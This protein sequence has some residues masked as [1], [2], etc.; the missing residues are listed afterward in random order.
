M[1]GFLAWF[2]RRFARTVETH[3]VVAHPP[4]MSAEGLGGALL[5]YEDHLEV[6]HFGFAHMLVEFVTFHTPRLST[7][8]RLS[9]ITAIEIV[10]PVVMPDYLVVSYA[11]AP[12][13]EGGYLHRAFSANSLLMSYFD[14]RDFFVIFDR[15][16]RAD[17]RRDPTAIVM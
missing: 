1:A 11:G 5:L 8:I 16:A 12:P 17:E 10:R 3:Q 9:E 15:I 6:Q 2:R 13:L 7:R 14:N 4:V